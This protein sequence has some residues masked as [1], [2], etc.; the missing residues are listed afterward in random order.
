MPN[1]KNF[2]LALSESVIARWT[3]PALCSIT[4]KACASCSWPDRACR[5]RRELLVGGGR[6]AGGERRVADLA[7]GARRRFG[8]REQCRRHRTEHRVV[9]N[10]SAGRVLE[11]ANDRGHAEVQVGE[12][13]APAAPPIRRPAGPVPVARTAPANAAPARSAP[14]MAAAAPP[15]CPPR[16]WAAEPAEP[17]APLT[18]ATRPRILSIDAPLGCRRFDRAQGPIEFDVLAGLLDLLECLLP[19]LAD[20]ASACRI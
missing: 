3:S 1:E 11:R 9:L 6:G 12:C 15:T 16:T 10:T 4:A 20:L 2:R 13:V 17:K 14:D 18:L 19:G 5:R 7:R 8:E